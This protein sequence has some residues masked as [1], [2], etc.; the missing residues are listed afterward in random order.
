MF[1]RFLA[2]ISFLSLIVLGGYVFLY[3]PPHSTEESIDPYKFLSEYQ[4]NWQ[5]QSLSE[6]EKIG[7]GYLYTAIKDAENQESTISYTNEEK[8]ATLLPGVRVPFTNLS[9]TQERLTA[10]LEAFLRDNPQFFY[11]SRTY[12]LEGHES[13]KESNASYDA[14]LLQFTLPLGERRT[15]IQQLSATVDELISGC[16]TNA[17]DYEKELYLHDQ[18]AS[19]C[20]YDT[21]AASSQA[22]VYHN[23]YTAY[24]ALIEGKAVCEGYAKAMQ[25]L[26][27]KANLPSTVV[28]GLSLTSGE[29]HMWNQVAIHG[30]NYFLDPTWNDHNNQTQ[31]TY[32]NL[33]SEML[34]ATHTIDDN[35]PAIGECTA[36]QDNYFVRNNAY[37]DT[38]EREKIAYQIALQLS[39][40][41]A[42][43]QLR[44]APDKYSNGQLFLK[45]RT[46]TIEKVNA[47]LA[48]TGLSLWNYQLWA[49]EEQRVLTLTK[50]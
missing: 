8:K 5:Y 28:S 23:A 47:Y 40:G 14:V 16:P 2:L 22:D 18:L 38:Y 11:I 31:H 10:V 9:L 15:A 19:R 33:T 13:N 20:V 17:D 21:I 48:G 37:I 50:E 42:I 27:L 12:H 36:T 25:L 26:L 43:I 35:Q 30:E 34:R 41:N 6:E 1:K 4:N 3:T 7:Y 24:G 45:N 44:F 32:F 46:L 49:D 39:N 29:N